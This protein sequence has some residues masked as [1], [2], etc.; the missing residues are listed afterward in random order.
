LPQWSFG[1]IEAAPSV[2]D[3]RELVRIHRESLVDFFKFDELDPAESN[4]SQLPAK[5]FLWD[6][7]SVDLI[8]LIKKPT[9]VV[10]TSEKAV[11]MKEI[12]TLPQRSLD[13]FEMMALETL[14][15][16]QEL[17]V[18]RH[19]NTLR[20]VGALKASKGC[21][22]CHE[23]NQDDLLGAFSY[24]LRLAVY[25]APTPRGWIVMPPGGGVP[26]GQKSMPG[27]GPRR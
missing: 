17:Y 6:V 27:N 2:P 15:K 1:D 4:T 16:G 9:P 13:I 25:R 10:Y 3:P 12:K 19:V 14:L 26:A 21:L 18:R 7:K 8:S 22:G 23:G 24:T 5:K 11:A 20:M